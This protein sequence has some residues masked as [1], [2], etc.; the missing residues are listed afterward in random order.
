M[1][2]EESEDEKDLA[3]YVDPLSGHTY[4]VI[5]NPIADQDAYRY[6][7]LCA[8]VPDWIK[9]VNTAR[10]VSRTP[11]IQIYDSFD[12][13]AEVMG[14]PETKRRVAAFIREARI[15]GGAHHLV[16]DRRKP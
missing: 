1:R 3:A 12:I 6:R 4:A 11:R 16:K 14:S 2:I 7:L 10:S 5:C 13:P 15:L 8:Q 9:Q